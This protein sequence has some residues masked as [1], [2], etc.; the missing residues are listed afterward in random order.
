MRHFY[1]FCLLLL[2]GTQAFAQQDFR[3]GYIVR[4]GDTLTGHVDYRGAIRNSRI[5]TFRSSPEAQ[6]QAFTP[7][8]IA[9]YG[10]LEEKK[11]YESWRV[12]S[13]DG[14][15][16]E[17]LFLHLL[18][19]GKASV[20]TLRDERDRDRFYLAHNG[21][22]LVELVESSYTQKDPKSGK[23]Y[24]ILDQAYLGVL[25]SAFADCPDITQKRL[26]TVKLN[27]NSLHKV[28]L[29]YNLCTNATIAHVQPQ[30]RVKVQVMPLL[31]YTHGSLKPYGYSYHAAVDYQN[32]SPG[33]GGG[34]GIN[35]SNAALSEKLSVQVELLYAPYRFNGEV[36]DVPYFDGLTDHQVTFNLDYLKVPIQL[37]YTL[38]TGS[39]R[40]FLNLGVS[41]SHVLRSERIERMRNTTKGNSYGEAYEPLFGAFRNYTFGWLAGAGVLYPISERQALLLETRYEQVEGFSDTRGMRFPIHSLS[42]LAGFRF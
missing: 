16:Y 4:N 29:E 28:A 36:L 10:F 8:D 14:Q 20:Y 24:K 1:L 12:P 21:A 3:P 33:I 13:P 11:A 6:P 31:S 9:A 30:V 34:L 40:P 22:E 26:S 17:Q 39:I 7:A 2:S 27:A 32:T 5:A 41:Y 18:I 35:F 37:R 38:P 42:V 15:R 25:T 23:I 19:K